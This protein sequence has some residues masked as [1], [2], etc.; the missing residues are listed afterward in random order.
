MGRRVISASQVSSKGKDVEGT[1]LL[2]SDALRA[3]IR[4]LQLAQVM[5]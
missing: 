5:S 3:L 2:D 4:L 1:P